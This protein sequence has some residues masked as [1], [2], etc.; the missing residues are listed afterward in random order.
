MAHGLPEFEQGI[1]GEEHGYY[2]LTIF[3]IWVPDEAERFRVCLDFCLRGSHFLRLFEGLSPWLG[4]VVLLL[5]LC[6]P[7]RRVRNDT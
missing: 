1:E 6:A 4:L 2:T 3:T 7:A 5:G